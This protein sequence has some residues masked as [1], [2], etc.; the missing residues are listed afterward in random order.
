MKNLL[1][2][3]IKLIQDEYADLL[4]VLIPQ[5][6]DDGCI[7]SA[8]DSIALFW[9]RRKDIIDSFLRYVVREQN[10]YIYT[11]ATYFDVENGEQYP[12]LL[13]GD[14]HIFD[15]PLGRYCEICYSGNAPERLSEKVLICAKDNI[16]ILEKCR[17]E[18]L[19]LPL[20]FMGTGVEEKEFLKI[21]E[22]I[23]LEFFPDI[24]DLNAYFELCKTKATIA[25]YIDSS[26]VNSVIFDEKDSWD[27]PILDRIE[28]TIV[29]TQ[30]IMGEGYEE[31]VLFYFALYGPIQQAID[32]ILLSLE[33]NCIPLLRY[34][35][36]LHYVLAILPNFKGK[37]S[38]EEI[39]KKI[40]VLNTVYKMF[41][42]ECAASMPLDE[43]KI[44]VS[45][46]GFERLVL[47]CYEQCNLKGNH[48]IFFREC[49]KIVSEFQD[50]CIK[51]KKE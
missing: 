17:T 15:D 30:K 1:T 3:K 9:R 39:I 26:K 18:I 43:Y 47:D 42:Q 49:A 22:Q 44:M 50:Y 24:K 13:M 7:H 28:N 11:A 19:I 25:R 40:I 37:E 33:Y 20:R 45:E 51:A 6:E 21:G 48:H 12:F 23:F 16:G 46:F 35:V 38:L 2:D 32:I 10:A 34:P 4:K 31:G 14:L 29:E 27:M 8:L 5:L 36:A 41:D